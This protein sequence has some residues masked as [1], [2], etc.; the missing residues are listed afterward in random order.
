MSSLICW[1]KM[2]IMPLTLNRLVLSA[3]NICKQFGLRSGPTERC[4]S[5]LFDTRIVFLKDFFEKVD[6][7]KNQLTTKKSGKNLPGA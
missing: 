1:M 4:D 7:E 5:K 3:D 6:F 2:L